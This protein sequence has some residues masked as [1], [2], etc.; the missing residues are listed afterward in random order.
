MYLYFCWFHHESGEELVVTVL[1]WAWARARG[2][3]WRAARTSQ[4]EARL[5]GCPMMRTRGI[6]RGR[7]LVNRKVS[8]KSIGCRS[9][10]RLGRRLLLRLCL[11]RLE[12]WRY[13][14]GRLI[15][16]E[17]LGSQA[18]LRSLCRQVD[19]GSLRILRRLGG[20]S[21]LGSPIYLRTW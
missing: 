19:N 5:Q 21:R 1:P 2:N 16:T 14:H 3:P 18:G 9:T 12:C 13:L 10:R 8:A 6:F 15:N 7:G 11:M 4:M 17:A 20:R